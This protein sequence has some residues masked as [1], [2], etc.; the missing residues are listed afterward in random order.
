MGVTQW[1]GMFDRM[2][3]LLKMLS[4]LFESRKRAERDASDL[5]AMQIDYGSE[6]K[7]VLWQRANDTDLAERDR[8]HW[9]RLLKKAE[10]LKA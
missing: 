5:A 7:T 6:L 3:N 4:R 9:Q 10:S 1:T 2:W 8:R